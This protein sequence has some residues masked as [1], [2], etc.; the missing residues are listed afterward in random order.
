[1]PVS[2]AP[3]ASR[4]SAA[5]DTAGA[6]RRTDVEVG[7]LG[8]A[9]IATTE[10]RKAERRCLLLGDERVLRR[11]RSR[12]PP[13]ARAR[14]RRGRA[15]VAA[16]RRRTPG[17]APRAQAGR[18]GRRGVP[19]W[20]QVTAR[21]TAGSDAGVVEG[22]GNLEEVLERLVGHTLQV[23]PGRQAGAGEDPRRRKGDAAIGD[24][25]AGVGECIEAC[26]GA[27]AC[28]ARR[29]RHTR[30]LGGKDATQPLGCASM[31]FAT[32]ACADALAV[33][34]GL[35][36][37][38][39]AGGDDQRIVPL[40]E[41]REPGPHAHRREEPLHDLLEGCRHGLHLER[42][43]LVQR[44]PASDLLLGCV[45]DRRGRRSARSPCAA[46]RPR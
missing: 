9:R 27:S 26:H 44:Q 12:E 18:P 41:L 1:M 38:A 42:D 4:T 20:R 29:T 13:R 45:E 5:R 2:S 15:L 36:E 6:C 7:E 43:H 3:T 16:A 8:E 10:Q 32:H 17:R 23:E 34:H 46:C 28:R 40:D 11:R 31:R 22:G 39:E 21:E 35:D 37:L 33:E 25:V 30:A 14:R 19:P 24:A